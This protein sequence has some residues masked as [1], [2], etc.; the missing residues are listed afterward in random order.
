MQLLSMGFRPFFLLG[1]LAA[2]Y[3]GTFW[4]LFLHGIVI[5]KGINPMAWHAHEMLHGFAA[6]ILAGF[7]LTASSNWTRTRGLHGPALGLLVVIWLLARV[8]FVFLWFSG[9]SLLVWISPVF[10]LGLLVALA[11][12]LIKA[13]QWHNVGLVGWVAVLAIADGLYAWSHTGAV[14]GLDFKANLMALNGFII[15]LCILGGRVIPFFTGNKFPGL[16][17]RR[18]PV[19]EWL[20]LAALALL[21]LCDLGSKQP[22]CG[23]VMAMIA[24][25]AVLARMRH[26]HSVETRS[27]P[28]LWILHLG[29]LFIPLGLFTRSLTLNFANFPQSAWI[30]VLTVGALSTLI[31]AMITRVSLGHTGRMIHASRL[32]V[33]AYAAILMALLLRVTAVWWLNPHVRDASML[34]FIG[35]FAIFV[36]QYTPILT[37]PR[38]DGKPG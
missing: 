32:T 11:P 12:K 28:I 13:R 31:L 18:D 33:M 22:E 3:L 16:G 14:S 20:S 8:S 34:F 19:A 24:A 2:V 15:I 6:A 27:Q 23:G 26:W 1:S 29:Y 17:V 21:A 10:C 4:L 35:A 38:A 5:P 30:H 36:V 25:I 7:L 37:A 9:P